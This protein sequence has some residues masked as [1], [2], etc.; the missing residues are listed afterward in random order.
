MLVIVLCRKRLHATRK[1]RTRIMRFDEQRARTAFPAMLATV[2][3]VHIHIWL[4]Y[5]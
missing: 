4:R 3:V 2:V 1:A 5:F